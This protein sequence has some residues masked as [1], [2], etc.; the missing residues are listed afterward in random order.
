MLI[1]GFNTF[2]CTKSTTQLAYYYL[3]RRDSFQDRS[4]VVL[5]G[6]PRVLV[7]TCLTS[8]AGV[9][10]GGDAPSLSSLALWAL[11]WSGNLSC[12]LMSPAHDC[13]PHES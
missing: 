7:P 4:P 8:P 5:Y 10:G 2:L 9:W 3:P 6:V 12:F 1:F 11:G 13:W